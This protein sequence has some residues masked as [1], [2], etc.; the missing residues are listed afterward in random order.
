M[1]E[2]AKIGLFHNLVS[3]VRNFCETRSEP[4]PTWTFEGR[5]KL[6]GANAGVRRTLSDDGIPTFTL[7]SRRLLLKGKN[8]LSGFAPFIQKI[9]VSDLDDL[10]DEVFG[11]SCKDC[12]LYGEWVGK[13]TAKGTTALNSMEKHWVLFSG[14]VTGESVFQ[15]VTASREALRIFNVHAVPSWKITINFE[16]PAASL[17]ELQRL[18]DAVEEDC[19][20]GRYMNQPGQ[21]EGIVWKCL[22]FPD[23][24][25]LWFKTKGAKHKKGKKREPVTVDPVVAASMQEFVSRAL[26]EVRLE[27]AIDHIVE[28]GKAVEI[29]SLGVFLKFLLQDMYL[30]EKDTLAA[31]QLEW[32]PVSKLLTTSA[33]EWFQA[34]LEKN[35]RQH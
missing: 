34:L 13:G 20:W 19:P 9:P 5:V 24:D 4:L 32:K 12:T 14:N 6:H 2:F 10:F 1:Q 11:P 15:E 33:R 31:S 30:E 8:T 28:L 22:E 23:N 7:Q 29:Q 26:T 18:T 21:G 16:D 17:D 25:L 3:R 35:V 27:Q